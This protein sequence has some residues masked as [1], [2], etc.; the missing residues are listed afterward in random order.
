MGAGYHRN[1]PV[2]QREEAVPLKGSRVSVQIRPG[3][4]L[5]CGLARVR[6]QSGPLAH[7]AQP[8]RLSG[9]SGAADCFVK[10]SWNWPQG[11][12]GRIE[13]SALC[14]VTGQQ[15]GRCVDFRTVMNDPARP[16]RDNGIRAKQP[17]FLLITRSR[18]VRHGRQ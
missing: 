12:E 17:R 5:T 2:A 1:A 15:T 3:V 4:P 6:P 7:A 13:F 11:N 8:F 16:A 9:H 10:F 14:A 18:P